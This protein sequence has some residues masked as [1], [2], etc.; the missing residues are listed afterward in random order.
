MARS[1]NKVADGLA[2]LTM[3]QARSWKRD[4]N[5]CQD[6][7]K[8]NWIIQTDGGRRSENCAA[9]ALVVGIWALDE[10]TLHYEPWFAQCTFLTGGATVFQT[11]AIALDTAVRWCKKKVEILQQES[12]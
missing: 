8:A 7:L 2:D 1:H 9:A 10:G 12:G 4:Y 3:D 6:P 11:E 5:I